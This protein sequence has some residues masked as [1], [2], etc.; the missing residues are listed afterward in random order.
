[1]QKKKKKKTL[2]ATLTTKAEFVSCF[3]AMSC[4][5]WL[6][7][8]ISRLQVVDS[9]SKPL[10]I[11]CNNSATV[12]LAKNNKS[13]SRSKYIDIKYLAI[14]EHVKSNKVAI[15]HISTRLMIADPLTKGL[16]PKTYKENVEHMGLTSVL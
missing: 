14:R 16:P 11:Y 7:S 8:F 12:F 15:E 1:M 2:V 4:A 3:E 5:I 13:G 10:R 6:R 9:I